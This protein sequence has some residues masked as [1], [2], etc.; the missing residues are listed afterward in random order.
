MFSAQAAGNIYSLELRVTHNPAQDLSPADPDR[1][2]WKEVFVTNV[3]LKLMFNLEDGLEVNGGQ[4]EFK[5]P[6]AENGQFKIGDWIDLPRP[7]PRGPVAVE[8]STWGSIKAAY[9]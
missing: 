9:N 7:A 6:P 5:F 1:D 4:A 8:G 2:G 3:Y